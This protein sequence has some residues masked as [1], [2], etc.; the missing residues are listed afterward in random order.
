M[1][2]ILSFYG[3]YCNRTGAYTTGNTTEDRKSTDTRPDPIP[4]F[5][6]FLNDPDEDDYPSAIFP[7]L[8]NV[9]KVSGCATSG[10]CVEVAIDKEAQGEVFLD[11]NGNG[12]YDAGTVDVQLNGI[13]DEGT[14][15]IPWDGLDGLGSPVSAGTYI[16]GYVKAIAGLTNFPVWDAE[17]NTEGVN[18]AIVRPVAD[19][20]FVFWD[21]T[22]ISGGTAE[23]TGVNSPAHSW[24]G[25]FGNNRL[26]NTWWYTF[27]I[28]EEF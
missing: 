23:L 7:T 21:D 15:C 12:V 17:D 14:N 18:V 8:T 25:N 2:W 28:N 11:L 27:T 26:I 19:P 1:A 16:S 6:L 22:N 5:K 9:P 4:E 24:S 13:L 10:Y 3:V 20:P